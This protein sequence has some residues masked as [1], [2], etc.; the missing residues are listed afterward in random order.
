M[1][2]SYDEGTLEE[3]GLKLNEDQKD[4]IMDVTQEIWPIVPGG[5][6]SLQGA[7]EQLVTKA[8]KKRNSTARNNPSV[9]WMAILVR[10]AI[11]EGERDYISRG[12]FNMNLLPMDL[13]SE[14]GLGRLCTTARL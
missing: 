10:S 9:W 2:H 6:G 1:V 11:S 14:G 3:M 7:I 4:D 8:I 13:T 5:L 12:R